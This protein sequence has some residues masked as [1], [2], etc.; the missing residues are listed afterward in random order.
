MAGRAHEPR[1]WAPANE[2]SRQVVGR[3]EHIA[4]GNHDPVVMRGMP[5]LDKIVQLRI[6][7]G[8]VVADKKSSFYVGIRFHQIVDYWHR[9]I[10]RGGAAENQ[11]VVRVIEGK[12]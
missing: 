7:C 1:A 12:A 4:V 5:A 3:H 9:S 11:L 10:V 6:G 8:A 2:Q